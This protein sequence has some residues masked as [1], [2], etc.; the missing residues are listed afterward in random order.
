M[1]AIVKKELVSKF[2][3]KLLVG[4]WVF[5][6]I[7][8]LTY[9]SGQFRPT[10]HLYK[11]AFH[12]R[13]KV[14]GCASV[15]DSNFLT[16]APF[17]KI[18]SGELNPHMLVDAIGQII[19]VGEL[20]ELEAN[21]KPTTK[22]D[23][24]IRDQMDERM[25][26][27]LW[28]TYAQQVYRACQESEGKNSHVLRWLQLKG[29]TTVST[30]G[31]PLKIC[32]ARLRVLCTIYAIDTDWAWYYIN[33]KTC[34]KKVNHI[35]AGVN[36]VN[37][38]GKKPRFWCETCKSFVTN[39]VSSTGEAKLLLF[40]SICSEIIGE[41]ATSVLNGSV[42][43][44]ED[45]EDLP[46]SVKNLISKTF[47]FLVWVEK[48][49]ISDGKEIYKVSKVLLKD[50]LLE[51]QL[52]ED[53]TE[54]VNHASIVSGDKVPLMLENGNGSPD[55]TTPSSK[56]VYARETS[57][58]EGSSSSKKVCVVPLD[59]EKSL[60]ENAEHG[61]ALN[62]QVADSKEVT[63]PTEV[64]TSKVPVETEN[65]QALVP[66]TVVV[67]Q[68]IKKEMARNMATVRVKVEKNKMSELVKSDFTDYLFSNELE[69]SA[70]DNVP[71]VTDAI[72]VVASVSSIK[73]F[74]Y[75]CNKGET[76]Y[77]AKYV[78]FELIDN[79]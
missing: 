10:N 24:E 60:S 22:I 78:S 61:V 57:G 5:I 30:Q 66:A 31:I 59:L 28:G 69:D 48:D 72:G 38:K 42:D 56:R 63:V 40:D 62:P 44:I 9:A 53:S 26:V 46:D 7:F 52:L 36:G 65:D 1:H 11:M 20:E 75:V 76:D 58:S 39:V 23:F 79:W 14:M 54:H 35:H 73:R 37:N 71:D 74:P 29:L 18:Q 49:N 32:L 6:E 43:E 19:T 77:E 2:V 55:S 8:G 51:E 15:S 47:L 25:Q 41:Y 16:L 27:T 17:S 70:T 67:K 21:N 68:E 4:E 45:P 33:C 3:H 50:G 13:T 12:V 64:K 34:N